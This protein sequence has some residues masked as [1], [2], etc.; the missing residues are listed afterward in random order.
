MKRRGMHIDFQWEYQKDLD[1]GGKII[2]R[3]VLR[4]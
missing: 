4:K 1:V 3:W 2:L